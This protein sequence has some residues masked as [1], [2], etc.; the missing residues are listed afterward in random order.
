MKTCIVIP[1]KD[2][3]QS[4]QRLSAVLNKG[5]RQALALSLFEQTLEFLRCHFSDY[6]VLVVTSSKRIAIIATRF[7]AQVLMEIQPAGLNG[8]ARLAAQWSCA[9]GFDT[10]LLIPADIAVLDEQEIKHLLSHRR[11]TPSVVICPSSD[12]GTNA[13]MT[14]PP[15]VLPFCFGIQSSRAHLAAAFARGVHCTQLQMM[16]IA[17]DVDNPEDLDHLASLPNR[18]PAQQVM[19]LWNRQ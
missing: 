16:N 12:E 4:K 5:H 13:L 15:D 3:S 2:P 8:A 14:S 19:S 6:P 18:V 11:A 9:Q 7:D 17:F 1:M 10:Q